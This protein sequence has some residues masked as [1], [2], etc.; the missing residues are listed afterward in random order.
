[1]LLLGVKKVPELRFL[2]RDG[3][4]WTTD[5]DGII[6]ALLAAEITAKLQKDPGDI[7]RDLSHELGEPFYSRTEAPAT[8][9]Q[10]ETLAN[11]SRETL[12]TRELA[13]EIILSILTSAPGDGQ[14]IGGFKVVAQSGWF[15]ARP[16]GTEDI[17]KIYA[18]SFRDKLHLQQI[19]SEAQDIVAKIMVRSLSSVGSHA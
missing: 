17:Y 1:M 18:E 6:P 2:R 10:K 9:A 15:A 8:A 11:V 19:E 3:T 5:K 4:V 16:S 13:G 12:K 7:F 14:L